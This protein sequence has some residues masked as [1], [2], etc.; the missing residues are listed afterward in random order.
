MLIALGTFWFRDAHSLIFLG[1]FVGLFM[2]VAAY[3]LDYLHPA[4]AY[5]LPWLTI[6]FFSTVPISEHARALN[7]S[8]SAFLLATVFVWLLSTLLAPVAPWLLKGSDK[9]SAAREPPELRPGLGS[10]V[11]GGFAIA[12]G[13]A[14]LNVAFSG[15]VPLISLLTTGDSRYLDFGI[16]TVYGAFLAYSN[17]LACLAFYLYLRSRQR[18]YLLLFLSIVCVHFVFITRQNLITLLVE[19]FVVRCLT[20]G[21][22][23]RST[24]TILVVLGL[25]AFSAIGELR[26]GDIKEIV[27][28]DQNYMWV[29]TSAIWLYAYSYFSVLNLENMML[30]SGAPFHDG[31]MWNRLLPSIFRAEVDHGDFLEIASMNVSSYVY[32]IYMD[33]GSVGVLFWTALLG[34]V[35]AFFY[36]RALRERQF[37]HIGAYA[38]LFFCALMSFF[39]DFWF[40]LPVIFQIFFFWLF[41][42]IFF[43]HRRASSTVAT[44]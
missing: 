7:F 43:R 9:R 18:L 5:F 24:I 40:Y 15:Y 32:P 36:Y 39:I 41:N 19:A 25:S 33:V 6:L 34:S 44:T 37:F 3:K 17:A 29:P 8:T 2:L 11:V 42:R 30:F 35:T 12:Y 22:V 10:L 13:I 28:V 31:Y 1:C 38:C 23:S 26:S 4:V 14:A 20:V 27:R 16:P 21:R